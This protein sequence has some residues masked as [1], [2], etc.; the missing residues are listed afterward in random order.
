MN[1]DTSNIKFIR[2][3]STAQQALGFL[4]PIPL[5]E[6]KYS[7][8]EELADLLYDF[9]KEKQIQ[10]LRN[11]HTHR[12]ITSRQIA[13]EYLNLA[14]ILKI[15]H[16]SKLSDK[17][18]VLKSLITEKQRTSLFQGMDRP[19]YLTKEQQVYFLKL[20][21]DQ[22]GDVLIPFIN[23]LAEWFKRRNGTKIERLDCAY[24]FIEAL[25]E[26]GL[27]RIAE[28]FDELIKRKG[29][30]STPV[31]R[32]T[33]R[34]QSLTDIGILTKETPLT[35]QNRYTYKYINRLDA[36]AHNFPKDK[37]MTSLIETYYHRYCKAFY[38]YASKCPE[39]DLEK[40]LLTAHLKLSDRYGVS[41]RTGLYFLTSVLAFHNKYAIEEQDAANA[42]KNLSAKNPRE[43]YT[44]VDEFG[45]PK[46]VCIDLSFA[47]RELNKSA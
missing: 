11:F 20:L 24:I 29:K 4:L 42:F 9:V 13:L 45:E 14:T 15:F 46:F 10:W 31:Y 39:S 30:D 37:S 19:L 25:R 28:N 22:D 27:K 1:H 32:V 16:N 5:M 43:V 17:G 8:K 7:S 3:T 21:L 12:K 18:L 44:A 40:I 36:I 41:Y 33:F 26:A 23:G 6:G 38:G 47:K 35:L 34:L 2:R